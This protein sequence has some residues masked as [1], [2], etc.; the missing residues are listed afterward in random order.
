MVLTGCDGVHSVVG[1][2][3]GLGVVADSG[4]VAVRVL[5]VHPQGHGLKTE[6]QQSLTSGVRA[7]FVPLDDKHTYW[8][9]ICPSPS[10]GAGIAGLATALALKRTGVESFLVLE[11]AEEL[12]TSGSALALFPNAGLALESLGISHKLASIYAPFQKGYVTN[13]DN[14]VT[15][16]IN[17]SLFNGGAGFRPGVINRKAL[18]KALAEEL[19]HNSIR[20]SSKLTAI[21]T[22]THEGSSIAVIHMKDGTIIKTKVLIGCDGVHSVVGRWLGLSE[23]VD[24]G[25]VAVRVL[26]VYPEGHGL[27]TD[28]QQFVTSGIRAGFIPLD[29]K[30]IYWYLICPAPSKGTE[31][32]TDPKETQR[33]ILENHAKNLPKKFKDVVERS[34]FST[35][36][37]APLKFRYP[38]QVMFGNLNKENVAVAGDAMHPMT[39]DL[40]QGGCTALEDAVVLGR[41]I[42]TSFIQNGGVIVPKEIP[43]VLSNYV[44]E[45]R[46]RVSS[47]ILGSYVAGW[48]QQRNS[49]VIKY[50]RDVFFYKYLG[51]IAAGAVCFDCGKLPSIHEDKG[52]LKKIK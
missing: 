16:E 39:P 52:E 14:G 15:Q 18:L 38:W 10:K 40:G 7:G 21:E 11:R 34:D 1:R 25:R 5:F 49:A 9:L 32:E 41:H 42:G 27:K 4:R 50:L 31:L 37:W 22:K 36:S 46:L 44:E 47:L 6:T 51:R 28:N 3:L 29:D 8:F 2:W 24:S 19:P 12:R 48:V 20:F 26:S 30:H 17:Y 35:L 45:R 33:E 23:V 43:Q 13:V